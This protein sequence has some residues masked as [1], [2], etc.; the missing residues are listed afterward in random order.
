MPADPL[1][2]IVRIEIPLGGH[3]D[4]TRGLAN[5]LGL[6]EVL[7]QFPLAPVLPRKRIESGVIS[8]SRGGK[9]AL[10][11]FMSG[12]IFTIRYS[13]TFRRVYGYLRELAENFDGENGVEWIRTQRGGSKASR[14]D[15]VVPES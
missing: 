10:I 12:K 9:V 4:M 14:F 6:Q 15:S 1:K 5:F 8:R 11:K 3:M 7:Q 2:R 13:G